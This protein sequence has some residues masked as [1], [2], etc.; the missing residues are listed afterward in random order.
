M[1]K[2]KNNDYKEIK[3]SIK[4]AKYFLIGLIVTFVFLLFVRYNKYK[5]SK[6][7]IEHTKNIDY[8]I[9]ESINGGRRY[10]DKIIV[11]INKKKYIVEISKEQFYNLNYQKPKLYY[12]SKYQKIISDFELS[13]YQSQVKFTIFCV[14]LLFFPYKYFSLFLMEVK[15]IQ[16]FVKNEE[17]N[18]YQIYLDTINKKKQK[19]KITW[20]ELIKWCLYLIS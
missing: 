13:R 11:E 18:I 1:K 10:I 15:F 5:Y 20:F 6:Q 17:P 9:L 19:N 4:I 16:N 12:N 8:K 2:V 3:K 7:T 14:I